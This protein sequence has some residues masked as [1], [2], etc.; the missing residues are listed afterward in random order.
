[1]RFVLAD[2]LYLGYALISLVAADAAAYAVNSVSG[3]NYHS[4]IPQTL[5]NHLDVSGIGILRMDLK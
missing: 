4:I 5:K 1:M 2:S 3:E